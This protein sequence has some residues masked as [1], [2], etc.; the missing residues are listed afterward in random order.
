MMRRLIAS[1]LT[2]GVVATAGLL[3]SPGLDDVKADVEPEAA[4]CLR[5]LWFSP[6]IRL[7]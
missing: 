3:A 6:C 7:W 5:L 1:V 4:K 2:A